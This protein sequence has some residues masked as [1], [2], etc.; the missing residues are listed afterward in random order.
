[1]MDLLTDDLWNRPKAV[2]QTGGRHYPEVEL[3]SGRIDG[4][5]QL[6]VL[7]ED[8]DIMAFTTADLD[9][10][11]RPTAKRWSPCALTVCCAR[12]AICSR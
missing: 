5:K 4:A 2:A 11:S 12:P 7:N 8:I 9:H 10:P 1:M 3:A 6:K